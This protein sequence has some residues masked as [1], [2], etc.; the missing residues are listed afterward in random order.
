MA[1]NNKAAAIAAMKATAAALTG[2]AFAASEGEGAL[3]NA[4]KAACGAKPTV[5]QFSTYRR[6]IV[7]GA[8]ASHLAQQGDNRTD[9]VL[10]ALCV[11]LLDNYQG[12]TG[13]APVRDGMKGRRTKAQEDAYT[14]G[15]K[16]VQRVCERAGVENPEKR[17]K[18]GAATKAAAN[19][20]AKADKEKAAKAQ[21]KEANDKPVIRTFKKPEPFVEYA[22]VTVKA[23]QATYNRSAANVG[24]VSVSKIADA[25]TALFNATKETAKEMGMN[26]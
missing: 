21:A 9:K 7:V 1:K 22:L 23:L 6:A 3:V 13:T 16:V 15:R 26:V 18:A 2:K 10:F 4:L 24:P 14:Y 25:I 12:A 19:A 11:D 5:E 17:G 8:M 20:K